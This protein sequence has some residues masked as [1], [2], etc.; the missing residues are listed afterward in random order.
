M[1]QTKNVLQNAFGAISG[2]F[3]RYCTAAAGVYAEG[4]LQRYACALYSSSRCVCGGAL[5][6]IYMRTVQQQQVYVRRGTYNDIHAHCT[7]AAGVY[8][9]GHLQRP[10]PCQFRL[11]AAITKPERFVLVLARALALPSLPCLA[12]AFASRL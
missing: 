9:E 11:I 7:A 12:R 4:L 5:T 2:I 3:L 10:R 1:Y 6:T 8:A